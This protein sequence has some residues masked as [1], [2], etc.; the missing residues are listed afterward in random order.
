[1]GVDSEGEV[2][3][4]Q[5]PHPPQCGVLCTEELAQVL[6]EH[7]HQLG[8]T[9]NETIR[10]SSSLQK[11]TITYLV[12]AKVQK[13]GII[14]KDKYWRVHCLDEQNPKHIQAWLVNMCKKF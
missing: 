11:F 12:D 3:F 4:V 1:M 7:K 14:L 2:V 10:K 13:L 6:V 9:C 5:I 8:H